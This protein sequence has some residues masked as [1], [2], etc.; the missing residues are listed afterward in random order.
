MRCPF[1]EYS[2]SKV[3]DSRPFDEGAKIKRRRECISCGSRFTTFEIIER[4]PVVVIKRDNSRQVFDPN[5][6]LGGMI[7]ACEKRPV[8]LNVLNEAIYAIEKKLDS[9]PEREITSVRL[10]EMALE[11]LRTIDEIA[12]VRFAS[13]YRDFKDIQSFMDELNKMKSEDNN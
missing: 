7:R 3:L 6:L 8:T 9:M 5:K 12:Y 10:G 2:E 1:C 4:S 13:V 11:Q